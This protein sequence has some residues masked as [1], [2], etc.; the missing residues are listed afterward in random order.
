MRAS[1]H[2]C[3]F[4]VP[5]PGSKFLPMLPTLQRGVYLVTAYTTVLTCTF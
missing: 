3:V 1:T 5:I 4:E 2:T